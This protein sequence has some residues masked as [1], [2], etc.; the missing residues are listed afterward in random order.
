MIGLIKELV[1]NGSWSGTLAPSSATYS[2]AGTSSQ[3]N[4][5]PI[6]TALALFSTVA[7]NS[8]G[9]LPKPG[10]VGET[11]LVQNTGANP[12]LLY[13]EVGGKI[14]GGAANA[15]VSVAVDKAALCIAINA[16]DWVALV[17]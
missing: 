2:G 1:R 12:L 8:G 17:A 4:A 5:T 10:G 3:A 9:V 13:P 6:T 11:L 16:T 15:S 14:N 7:L